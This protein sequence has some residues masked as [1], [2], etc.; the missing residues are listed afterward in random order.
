[1]V[2]RARNDEGSVAEVDVGLLKAEQLPLSEPGVE[3]GQDRMDDRL[4]V[5][6]LEVP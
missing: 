1:M 2:V 5:V 4:A 3:R 6:T